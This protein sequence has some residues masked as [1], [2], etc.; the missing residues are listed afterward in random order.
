MAKKRDDEEDELGEDEFDPPDDRPW[1][2]EKWEAFMRESDL[3]S[4]RFGE[5]FET[6]I[7]DPNRDRIIAREM[8]WDWLTEALDEKEAA[9]AAGGTDAADES[10]EEDAEEE[11]KEWREEVA[12][13]QQEAQEEARDGASDDFDDDEELYEDEDDD[14]GPPTRDFRGERKSIPAYRI[15]FDTGMKIHHA[16]NPYLRGKPAES[17]Y[18]ELLGK[19]SIGCHIAA[20]KIAGGHAMGYDDDV[21]C[22]NIANCKRG[23]AGAEEAEQAFIELKEAGVLP[24][25]VVDALL[26]D[27]RAVIAAVKERIEDLR[28]RVWW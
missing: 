26:P 24:A 6:V 2:E 10:D 3:R 7:D 16:L 1:S 27:V 12:R 17:D 28:K 21:L 8:G 22:G 13:A 25:E 19:A 23:L 18:D 15:A 4:A 5:I 20:A 9:D 11:D 14:D